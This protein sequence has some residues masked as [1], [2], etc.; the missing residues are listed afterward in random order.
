[1]EP[2][3]AECPRHVAWKRTGTSTSDAQVRLGLCRVSGFEVA[4]EPATNGQA[5]LGLYTAATA[6]RL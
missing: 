5:G 3:D 2:S 6:D 1:L 4:V